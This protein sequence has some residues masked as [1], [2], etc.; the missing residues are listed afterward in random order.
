MFIWVRVTATWTRTFDPTYFTL[1]KLPPRYVPHRIILGYLEWR[2]HALIPLSSSY[3]GWV[4]LPKLCPW[5]G[6]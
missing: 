6:L 5:P 3:G 1:P 2:V 4:F